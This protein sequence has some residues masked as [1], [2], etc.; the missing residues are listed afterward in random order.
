M[1]QAVCA[2]CVYDGGVDALCF[3]DDRGR[4]EACKPRGN[5]KRALPDARGRFESNQAIS[6]TAYAI[7]YGGKAACCSASSGM[8]SELEGRRLRVL[9]QT[10]L[11]FMQGKYVLLRTSYLR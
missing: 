2:P 4:G 7:L 1:L 10:S 8:A 9:D 3:K 11:A 6:N 5:Q